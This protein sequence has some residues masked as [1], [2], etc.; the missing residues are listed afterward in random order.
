MEINKKY[1]INNDNVKVGDTLFSAIDGDVKIITI[2]E[3][4]DHP[5][6]TLESSYD[7]SGRL[8]SSDKFPTVF[9]SNPFICEDIIEE[10]L[11]SKWYYEVTPGTYEVCE[12]WLEFKNARLIGGFRD[13][14]LLV[15]SHPDGSF[16]YN[17]KISCLINNKQFGGYIQISYD[18]LKKYVLGPANIINNKKVNKV[19]NYNIDKEQYIRLFNIA[20]EKYQTLL[21]KT[22]ANQIIIDG[23][24][25]ISKDHY[26]KAYS[27]ANDS[28]KNIMDEIFGKET[29]EYEDGDLC[30]VLIGRSWC[31]RHSNGVKNE[32]YINQA[33][34][35]P[36]TE[37]TRH[38]LAN[39]ELPR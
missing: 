19:M 2:I 1:L 20:C 26:N 36:V 29:C 14:Q 22:Y 15:S 27:E 7:M 24:A 25:I 12:K 11:P 37:I 34:S 17:D 30:L 32:F 31:L 8:H 3:G 6:N 10:G 35:G 23:F 28:K 16:R 5:I 21:T 18:V 38:K 9:L 39:I 4:D 33:K 13:D